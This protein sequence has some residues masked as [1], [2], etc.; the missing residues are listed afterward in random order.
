MEGCIL[1]ARDAGS[2]G[3]LRETGKTPLAKRSKIAHKSCGSRAWANFFG[4]RHR[5]KF[6]AFS[7]HTC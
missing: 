6:V 3:P 5:E 4:E 7:P 1:H 2:I